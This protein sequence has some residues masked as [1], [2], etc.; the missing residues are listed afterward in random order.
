MPNP[1]FPQA[2]LSRMTF[3][4]LP[5]AQKPEVRDFC[6]S[7]SCKTVPQQEADSLACPAAFNLW[8]RFT[9]SSFHPPILLHVEPNSVLLHC[10]LWIRVAEAPVLLRALC[11]RCS[12]ARLL[13]FQAMPC[14]LVIMHISLFV[15]L[16]W[17]S[18]AR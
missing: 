6:M 9:N 1:S 16:L 13:R 17:L 11:L 8:T 12:G 4:S 5:V 18:D 15:S 7:W 3:L 10:L 14:G 2:P